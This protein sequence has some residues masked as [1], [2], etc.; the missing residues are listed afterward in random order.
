MVPLS[1]WPAMDD[2]QTFMSF[3]GLISNVQI[4]TALIEEYYLRLKHI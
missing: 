3:D 1:T 2:A 4:V